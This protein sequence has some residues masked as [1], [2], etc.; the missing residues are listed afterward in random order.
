M[1]KGFES[2][3]RQIEAEEARLKTR[4]SRLAEMEKA[5]GA[6]RLVKSGLGKLSGD[7]IDSLSAALKTHGI[8]EVLKRLA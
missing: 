4:R 2:E 1:A 5:E 7:Q 8:A 6:K 3:R